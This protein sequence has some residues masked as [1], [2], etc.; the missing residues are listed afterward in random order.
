MLWAG[1]NLPMFQG[2][3]FPKTILLWFELHPGSAGWMQAIVATIAI[4]AVYYA[5]TIPV[6]AEARYRAQERKMR[7]YGMALLLFP[8]II[9]LKGEIEMMVESGDISQS[10][11][12]VPQTLLSR[13]DELYLFGVAGVLL[14]HAIGLVNGVAAQTLRFQRQAATLADQDIQTNILQSIDFWQNNVGSLN[15]C[16]EKLDEALKQFDAIIREPGI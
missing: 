15:I 14:L 9:V 16:I 2:F 8:D 1:H 12:T 7:A 13:A 4:I 6:K 3:Q 10:P 11:V 5:A